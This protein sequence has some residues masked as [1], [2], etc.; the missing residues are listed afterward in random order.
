MSLLSEYEQR[1]SW[2]YEPI[3][4]FFHTA[5]SLKGKIN[6]NGSYAPF[7]GSTVVFRLGKQCLQTVQLMQRILYDK[8]E[9]TGMLAD[10]LPASTIHMTLHDLISPEICISQSEEAYESE[11]A[12][13][14][15][16]AAG[17][18]E[19]ICKEY[20]GR[21]ITM[22]SDRIVNMVSKSLVLMLKPQTEQ[23][24]ELLLEMYRRFDVI[25]KLPY[26]LTPHITLAYFKPGMLDGGRLGEAV[27]SVQ[28]NPDNAP[29]FEFCPESLTVQS[30]LD[31]QIYRD[32]P[33]RICFCCDGGLNRSVMAANILNHL[34]KERKLPVTGEARSAY[35]NTQGRFVSDRVWKTLENHGITPDRTYLSARYLEDKEI[36]CFTG[37]A[38]ISDG[39]ME[40]ISMLSLPEDRF[41]NL[42]VFFFGVRDPEYGEIT[43]EQAFKEL[44]DRVEKY[45]DAF[46]TD[47]RKHT[48]RLRHGYGSVLEKTGRI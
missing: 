16:K 20:N 14:V 24:Y 25:Q 29:V 44:Y 45:L 26:S 3:R 23:D 46:E 28:I 13:S 27:D 5:D 11:I 10:A 33:E 31:M 39:A 48:G 19:D 43:H 38:G 6:Q 21:G 12:D 36:S 41:Y 40:R 22:V 2:K 18:A 47:C 32:L 30:F 8:L 15:K 9:G 1:T 4:G 42:S 34:A 7:P 37:F 17:I 35:L